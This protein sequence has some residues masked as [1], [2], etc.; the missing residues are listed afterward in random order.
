MDKYDDEFFKDIDAQMKNLKFNFPKPEL[1]LEKTNLPS[2]I[3]Q[4][5]LNNGVSTLRNNY[6]I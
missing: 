1:L 3:K 6:Y 2:K 4:R 5:R